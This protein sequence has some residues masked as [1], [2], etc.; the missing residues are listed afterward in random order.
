[1]VTVYDVEPNGLLEEAKEKLKDIEE[2]EAPEWS[3]Y[4]KTSAG[5]ERPPENDDWWFSRTAAILRKVYIEGPIG[6]NRLRRKFSTRKNRGHKPEKTYLA[7]GKIIRT[8]LQQLEAADLVESKDKEGRK[9]SSKGQSFL[10]NLAYEIR[11]G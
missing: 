8:S 10:D 7:G 9:I 4:V 6:V 5:K 3:N 1:M 2:I 11:E